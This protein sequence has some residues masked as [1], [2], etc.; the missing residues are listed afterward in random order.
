MEKQLRF[1]EKPH[2]ICDNDAKLEDGRLAVDLLNN[3]SIPYISLGPSVD[4]PSLEHV[5]IEY[6]PF[7]YSG[8]EEIKTFIESW[9]NKKLPD[10]SGYV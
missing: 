5:I 9:K 6:G 3:V 7:V 8:I 4:I 10:I 2:L 1:M